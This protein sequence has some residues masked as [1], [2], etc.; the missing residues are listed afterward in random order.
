MLNDVECYEDKRKQERFE[1]D[2]VNERLIIQPV[3]Q[4]QIFRREHNFSENQRIDKSKTVELI[5]YL[6]L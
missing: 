3:A 4:T 6:M 5:I 2:R 1:E